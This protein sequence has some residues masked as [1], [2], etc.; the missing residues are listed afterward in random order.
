MNNI[1]LPSTYKAIKALNQ[2]ELN[3]LCKSKNLNIETLSRSAK[4]VLLCKLLNIPTSGD[5]EPVPK[6]PRLENYCLSSAELAEFRTLTP[7]YVQSLN[8]WEKSIEKLPDIDTG[9]VKKYLLSSKNPEF[10]HETLRCYKLSRAYQHLV[11]KTFITFH[12]MHFH[13]VTH[14]V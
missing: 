11:A 13:R 5:H 9:C 3:I 2:Q 14:F 8:G 7:E 1:E 10:G 4:E 12:S 6:H